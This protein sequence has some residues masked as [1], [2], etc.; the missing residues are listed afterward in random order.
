M[1]R[2]TGVTAGEVE[3]GLLCTHLGVSSASC[4][5]LDRLLI[6]PVLK[7]YDITYERVPN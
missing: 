3:C 1:R 4:S 5:A 2:S 7:C 6:A